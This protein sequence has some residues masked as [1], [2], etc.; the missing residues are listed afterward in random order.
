MPHAYT[1][2]SW[3]KIQSETQKKNNKNTDCSTANLWWWK[4]TPNW[5]LL[6][7]L[8]RMWGLTAAAEAQA[9][10]TD[11]NLHHSHNRQKCL[12]ACLPQTH[13]TNLLHFLQI[14][15][16]AI[17]VH[18]YFS[19]TVSIGINQEL[20]SWIDNR[21]DNWCQWSS[22]AMAAAPIVNQ[23]AAQWPIWGGE[24]KK[25]GEGGRRRWPIKLFGL[26]VDCAP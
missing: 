20:A 8:E 18:Y 11:A 7:L 15:S 6:L 12:P 2:F 21:I 25:G 9:L 10:D 3:L 22:G 4:V 19:T 1:Q 23:S 5:L 24:G 17:A 26:F 13:I 16:A 14:K